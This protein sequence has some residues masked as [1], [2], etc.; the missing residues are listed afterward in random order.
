MN[1]FFHKI[2]RGENDPG[3]GS[4]WQINP[5]YDHLLSNDQE[6]QRLLKQQNSTKNPLQRKRSKSRKKATHSD[7]S[8]TNNNNGSTRQNNSK[9]NTKEKRPSNTKPLSSP[10]TTSTTTDPCHLP[11][12]MD[13]VSLLSSQRLGGCISCSDAHYRPTFGSPIMG[14]SSDL[15]DSVSCSPAVLPMTLHN[16]ILDTPPQRATVLC[17]SLEEIIT[18]QESP[19]P[20]LPPWAAETRSYSPTPNTFDH[21]WA[22]THDVSSSTRVKHW[23]PPEVMWNTNNPSPQIDCQNKLQIAQLI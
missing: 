8:N 9:K 4:F 23:S 1:Q 3:K 19:A 15:V 18:T 22:E 14:T 7:N 17:S 21:P 10:P 6:L 5:E 20:L 2:P 16:R 13:W 12:D 11:C